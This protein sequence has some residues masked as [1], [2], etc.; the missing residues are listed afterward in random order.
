[1]SCQIF[2]FNVLMI[3]RIL[4][5]TFQVFE[6]SR[7][8]SDAG[9][10]AVLSSLPT[11]LYETY[12]RILERITKERKPDVARGIFQWL[13]VARRPLSSDEIAEST[14]LQPGRFTWDECYLPTNPSRLIEGCGNLVTYRVEDNSIQFAHST[15]LEFLLSSP[16]NTLTPELFIDQI[17]ADL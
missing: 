7:E 14:A 5:V 9:L 12:A 15:V 2:Y 8:N 11:G 3:T 1:M 10:R 6:L 17:E 13:A 4:W 16:S